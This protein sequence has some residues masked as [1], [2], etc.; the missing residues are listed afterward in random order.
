M[1]DN[2]PITPKLAHKMLRQL[3]IRNGDVILIKQSTELA[4]KGNMDVLA[5]ALGKMGHTTTIMIVVEDFDNIKVIDE[6]G[7]NKRGWF[8]ARHLSKLIKTN[9]DDTKS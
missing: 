5:E 1:T 3:R 7:M 2:I 9:N 6:L 8:K 4:I